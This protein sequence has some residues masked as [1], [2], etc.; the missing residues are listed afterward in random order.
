MNADTYQQLAQRTSPDDGHDRIL[1]G[2]M[3]L[4]GESGECMD[5]LKK[6]M[7]QGH[8]LN[9]EKLLEE[10]SDV[11]WYAAELATGLDASLGAVMNAN[12]EKLKRR[13]PNGF[14]PE[15]SINR[16]V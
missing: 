11:M 6:H 10:L 16:A 15:A 8:K 4:C 7:M 13:Y 14:S 9:R 5:V 12:I 3:G 2:C 1:N